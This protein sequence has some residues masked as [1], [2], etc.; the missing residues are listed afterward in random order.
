MDAA[1]VAIGDRRDRRCLDEPR[2]PGSAGEAQ[3]PKH[4]FPR[5][6]DQVIRIVRRMGGQR[7]CHVADVAA[8]IDG[9]APALVAGE[10]RFEK[11]QRGVRATKLATQVRLA[12]QIAQRGVDRPPLVEKHPDEV[13]GDIA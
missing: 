8:A 2:D 5:R 6:D 7:R 12:P 3:R 1:A 9:S 13:P 10:V 11:A 4:A